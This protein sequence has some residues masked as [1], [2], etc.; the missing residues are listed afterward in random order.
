MLA[1]NPSD[2]TIRVIL[3][4]CKPDF[5]LDSNDLRASTLVQEYVS[6]CTYIKYFALDISKIGKARFSSLL[7]DVKFVQTYRHK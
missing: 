1:P 7:V 5:A 6:G 4:L 2:F 3:I